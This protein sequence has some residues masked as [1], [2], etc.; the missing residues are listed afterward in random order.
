MI[1]NRMYTS[2]YNKYV[3]PCVLNESQESD[4]QKLAIKLVMDKFG[5]DKERANQFV[6]IELRNDIATSLKDKKIGKFTLGV[7]RMYC[8]GDLQNNSIK[9][10]LD[11]TLK[12]LSAHLNEYDKNLNGLSAQELI[13]KFE[14]VRQDNLEQNKK[15]IEAM[16]FGKSDYD[17]VRIDSF[18]QA[19][20]YYKY[21]NPDSRWCLTHMENQ[22]MS[23][24]CDEINQ[25][26]FCL[27]RG[28]ENIE[29][30]PGKNTP[31][32]EYGLSM[33][34]IIVNE[35]GELVHC[36]CRWNH[37]NGG[38]DNVMNEKQISEVVGVN[39]YKTFKPNNKWNDMVNTV[40]DD[41][42]NNVPLEEIFD[43]YDGMYG[44]GYDDVNG[45]K[46][47]C[48]KTKWNYINNKR[49]LLS[50]QWFDFINP[51]NTNDIAE[52]GLNDKRN[53]ID[54]NGELV[55]KQWFNLISGFDNGIAKVYLKKKVNF[56][57]D[58]GE[59][60]S[61][62]WFDKESSTN[63]KNIYKVELNGKYNI[64]DVNI[65]KVLSEQWFDRINEFYN[66]IAEVALKGKYN[67]INT[68]GKILS[69]E[70]FDLISPFAFNY[71]NNAVV[72]KNK[73]INVINTE[74]ELLFA[75][76]FD[77]ICSLNDDVIELEKNGKK[78]TYKF[79]DIQESLDYGRKNILKE[80]MMN[81]NNILYISID[82]DTKSRHK[83]KYFC[84][85]DVIEQFSD[86]AVYK[87]H[88]MTISHYSRLT[89]DI[90]DWCIKNKNKEF[91]FYVD[92]IGFSDKAIAVGIDIDGVPCTQAYPHITVAVNR[93]TGGKPVDS[94]YIRDFEDVYENVELSGTVVFHYKGEKDN[95]TLN[96]SL[97]EWYSLGSNDM[98]EEDAY[99]A[100][101]PGSDFNPDNITSDDLAQWC[102]TCGDFLFAYNFPI[103]GLRLRAANVSDIVNDIVNDIHNC[104]YIE[105][106]H[107]IDHLI[108]SREKDLYGMFTAVFKIC[109]IP[110]EKDYYVVYQEER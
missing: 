58:F 11:Y 25:L 103:G 9:N 60:L 30:I 92:N 89:P 49:E 65:G 63:K 51:F 4:S 35:N 8:D 105:V 76:W 106:S 6:R 97:C 86:D 55:C 88:H 61:E 23:Y 22:Y 64:F 21:T 42:K 71:N 15:D 29:N 94:N 31:L 68:Q 37:D 91:K 62:C 81:N 46:R 40:V 36:T 39:F 13:S 32:D 107:E 52:V 67:F 16:S 104:G 2:K 110:G 96:E 26:Y 90:L 69:K 95:T 27:K 102:S 101:Y 50:T 80:Q 84:E 41:L 48:L 85:E 38:T 1:M 70:W 28:F 59:L 17:I 74:G 54:R 43:M 18:E 72:V 75:R 19:K 83:L 99:L 87:C 14:R 53:F 98:S 44:Y 3:I 77:D 66:D 93:A 12:L 7:T 24:T 108:L 33:L 73:K 47:V 56:I 45:Y 82:L 57:N 109:D 5:W 78:Y 79:K 20:E 100:G 10:S 34:S